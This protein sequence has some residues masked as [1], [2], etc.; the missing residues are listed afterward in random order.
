MPILPSPFAEDF[1]TIKKEVMNMVKLVTEGNN[2]KIIGFPRRRQ[3]EKAL[4][5]SHFKIYMFDAAHRLVMF[6]PEMSFDILS[7][8]L[9]TFEERHSLT[10]E[11]RIEGLNEFID[12]R[13]RQLAHLQET[14]V[15]IED[16][17][18]IYIFSGSLM[19]RTFDIFSASAVAFALTFA[20]LNHLDYAL[21][22]F[23][24]D[25]SDEKENNN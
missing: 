21:Y 5:A 25:L 10:N 11:E 14:Y 1:K 20:D 15:D 19:I 18:S 9:I 16:I 8:K 6:I 17:F 2:E 4:S 23:D 7:T 12:T 24:Y 22:D 13:R 3:L